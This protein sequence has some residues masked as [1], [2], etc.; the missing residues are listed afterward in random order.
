MKQPT[1]GFALTGSF[2]T[3]E[4]AL[5]QMEELVRRGYQVL[6]VLSF[7][8]GMLDT[9]FMKADKELA[10]YD[11]AIEQLP[12]HYQQFIQLHL[13]EEQTWDYIKW[14][15][16][17]SSACMTKYRKVIAKHLFEWSKFLE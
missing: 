9:R 7:N 6:P 11:A 2:C 4:K 14:K 12:A 13:I 8:A 16:S 15:M 1:I 5:G 10:M 3:F 17:I